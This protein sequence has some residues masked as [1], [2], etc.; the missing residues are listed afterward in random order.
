MEKAKAERQT[1][2]S[3]LKGGSLGSRRVRGSG[4]KTGWRER[5]GCVYVDRWSL[6][7]EGASWAGT[8]IALGELD[9]PLN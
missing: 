7:G 9:V 5:W 6:R 8:L 1:P 3:V 2:K 4:S